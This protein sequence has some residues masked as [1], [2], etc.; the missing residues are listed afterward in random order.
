MTFGG[1]LINLVP[2]F[3]LLL[4]LGGLV[5]IVTDPSPVAV[6]FLVFA[7]YVLPPL[8][9]RLH[10]LIWPGVEGDSRLDAQTYSPWWASHKFQSIYEAL[11]FLERALRLLPG[12]Y[13]SW[14]RIWG[15][16]VG[17]RV[18]W[19]P[20]V[21]ITDR[22]LIRVGDDVVFGHKV[23][24]YGHLIRIRNGEMRLTVRSIS[25][26]DRVFIGAGS[27]LGP[28]ASIADDTVVPLLTDIGVGKTY[29]GAVNKGRL[30]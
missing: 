4:I 5:W 14:L 11:P 12:C 23:A 30:G 1:K 17:R 20:T 27:R 16:D 22:S 26:G 21:E 13:S 3:L 9:H 7:I 19:T 2:A 6:V 29:D 28:G 8:V 25:I 10:G 18:Y 15:G 24:C